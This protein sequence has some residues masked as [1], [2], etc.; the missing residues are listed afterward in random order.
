MPNFRHRLSRSQ[1]VIYDRSNAIP[2]IP[3]RVSPRLARAVSLLPVALAGDYADEG[4]RRRKVTKVAQVICDEICRVMRVS[5]L[6]VSVEGVRPI[7]DSS[8]Y[9][10]LYVSEGQSHEITVW[11]YTA[12]RR[13]VVAPRTLLRTLL[14]EVVHHLDYTKLALEESFHTDGF[15][16]R[17]SSLVRQLERAAKKS[18]ATGS[19]QASTRA[20]GRLALRSRRAN[21]AG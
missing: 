3:L 2:S 4:E 16:K 9:H 8:E 11:M 15:F 12:K 1:R 6:R 19:G 20:D 5:S 18:S 14:H 10:G 13:Q 21:D 17:E 7:E